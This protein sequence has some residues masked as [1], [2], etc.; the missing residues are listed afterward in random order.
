MSGVRASSIKIES[1]SSI[2]AK[3]KDKYYQQELSEEDLKNAYSG[4]LRELAEIEVK[5]ANHG[6]KKS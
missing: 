3:L 6:T 5:L 2:I 1:T 4:L